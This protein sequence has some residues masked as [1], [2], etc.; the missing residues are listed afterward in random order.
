[1]LILNTEAA[2]PK[3]KFMK[4]LLLFTSTT[5]II[6]SVFQDIKENSG[7]YAPWTVNC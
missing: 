2:P 7:I 5:V 3:I 1:M 4:C 6:L